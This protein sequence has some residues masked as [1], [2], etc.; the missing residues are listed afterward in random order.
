MRL[1][2]KEAYTRDVKKRMARIDLFSMNI[3]TINTGDII[4]IKG[5]KKTFCRCLPLYPDD[6]EKRI[7]RIN[8]I[9]RNNAKIDIDHVVAVSL[10]RVVPAKKIVLVLVKG[11]VSFPHQ[12]FMD[13][14]EGDVLIKGDNVTIQYYDS[15]CI[16]QVVAV[17]PPGVPV[18]VLANTVFDSIESK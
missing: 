12:Q 13:N 4:Q 9:I 14:L 18:N 3:L 17:D 5:E 16:F 8:E 2:V 1:L 11:T 15:P 6:E 10:A 7:I